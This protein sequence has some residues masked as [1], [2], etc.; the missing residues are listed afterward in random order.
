LIPDPE[1]PRPILRV[2]AYGPGELV[3]RTLAGPEELRPLLGKYPV[4]WLNVDGLGD[5]GVV[6]EIGAIF[7]LHKLAL[8]DVLGT[9][10]RPKLEAYEKTDFIV[11]LM[12]EGG[13]RIDTDQL[14][15]FL[16]QEF[17]V[18]F[19]ERRGD[20]FEL[21]RARLRDPQNQMRRLGPD[22][23]AY[24]LLDAVIDSYFPILEVLGE[25]LDQIEEE[26]LL[27]PAPEVIHRIHTVRKDL[28]GLRRAVWPQREVINS[29]R[30]GHCPRIRPE[31][32][33]YLADCYDHAVQIM[34]LL[35]TYR[36]LGGGL[37]EIYLSSIS[38]RLNEVMKVLTVWAT[39]LIS[40][41][42]VASIYGMNF[43]HMPELRSKWGY[44]VSLGVM[45]TIAGSLWIYFRRK[46][47]IG[48]P[49]K[50]AP[51]S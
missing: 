40:M 7:E 48:A 37:M 21:V 5:A 36:D 22:Y 23:L 47:W 12:P 39:I 17:L 16:G 10:Q 15:L 11:A 30:A 32:R 26:V 45:A 33:V 38:N 46:G 35:E 34:D 44:P 1:A 9:H 19:Q 18:S 20:C 43:V 3:D 2:I 27:E 25:R 41:T 50:P 6:A 49:R 14:S 29:L 13:E 51:K 42:F 8:E 31:T 24:A 4:L 28:L